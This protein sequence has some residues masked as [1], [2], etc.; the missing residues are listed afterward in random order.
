M[1]GEHFFSKT[2][3]V[4]TIK[5]LSAQKRILIIGAGFAGVR[6]A[7]D[8]ALLAERNKNLPYNLDITLVSKTKRHVEYPAMYEVAVTCLGEEPKNSEEQIS[9][10]VGILLKELFNKLPVRIRQGKVVKINTQNKEI[11][12]QD[13]STLPY[14]LL[15]IAMGTKLATHGISGVREHAFSV[16]ILSETLRLRYHLAQ[17]FKKGNDKALTFVVVGGGAT[18]VELASEL[19]N[20]AHHHCSMHNIERDKVHIIL[21]EG[22]NNILPSVP[23]QIRQKIERRLEK[24]GV[25]VRCNSTIQHVAS[26]HAL[27]GDN[28]KRIDTNTVIW[29]AGLQ[30]H[31]ILKASNLEIKAWGALADTTMH[32]QGRKDIFVAGDIAVLTAPD[33][34][35]SIPATVPVA[36]TQGALVARNIINQL[37][38][39]PFEHYQYHKMGQLIAIGGKY[40][41]I[42]MPSGWGW[43]GRLPW[44]VKRLVS[45]R[46]WLHLLPWYRALAFSLK[47]LRL[48]T[49]ND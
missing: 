14:D 28:N 40:A 45:L 41:V 16:K 38:N 29:A 26:D 30:A 1:V 21:M 48:H 44:I 34:K 20:H 49:S 42:I 7:Y 32:A 47:S 37:T 18:G 35:I 5:T 6:C 33:K 36:Y 22:K 31:P 15:V 13:K 43:A 39:Q 25:E 2:L 46:Y 23:M 8:L 10:S 3:S 27:I 11:I 12:L 19:A 9:A 4:A 17:Q 24:I